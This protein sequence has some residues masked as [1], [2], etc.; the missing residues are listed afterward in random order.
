MARVFG[1]VVS[2]NRNRAMTADSV[3]PTSKA[4]TRYPSEI[5][6]EMSVT[7]LCWLKYCVAGTR[8]S[9]T[10]AI[11]TKA[12]TA[13]KRRPHNGGTQ[14]TSVVSRICA[15]LRNAMTTPSMASQRN[16]KLAS[17]SV[18]KIGLLNT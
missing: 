16:R 9:S 15:S 1:V 7:E 3:M 4:A 13:E 11:T 18:Q 2:S 8:I 14:E 5:C 6:N 10:K 17:S 12:A